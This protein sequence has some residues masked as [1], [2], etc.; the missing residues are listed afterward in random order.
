MGSGKRAVRPHAAAS[1]LPVPTPDSSV[2]R[3]LVVNTVHTHTYIYMSIYICF[4]IH[5][6][7]YTYVNLWTYVLFFWY[8]YV[9]LLCP[10]S[11]SGDRVSEWGLVTYR[12]ASWSLLGRVGLVTLQDAWGS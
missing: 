11:G 10:D 7:I 5:T 2:S 1:P 9:G 12:E 8:I 6:Y 3:F 4:Y